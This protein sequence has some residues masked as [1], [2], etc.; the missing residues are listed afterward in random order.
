MLSDRWREVTPKINQYRH[1]DVCAFGRDGPGG[2]G[3]EA[4][5]AE[6]DQR[7]A[8]MAGP[9]GEPPW[10]HAVAHHGGSHWLDQRRSAD[11]SSLRGSERV[12]AQCHR[13]SAGGQP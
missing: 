2:I 5:R 6:R 7:R 9:A 10:R 1:R 13:H 8:L 4:A 3:T 11:G 12:L